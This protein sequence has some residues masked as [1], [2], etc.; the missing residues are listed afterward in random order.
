MCDRPATERIEVTPEMIEA[1]VS[2]Y[3]DF[4]PEFDGADWPANMIAAVYL[5]M[6]L[7]Q[8]GRGPHNQN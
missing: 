1:G 6:S 4:D 5:A 7:V 2:R 3:Y 8:N